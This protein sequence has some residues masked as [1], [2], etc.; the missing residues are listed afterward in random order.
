M[1]LSGGGWHALTL[2]EGRD[3]ASGVPATPWQGV[4]HSLQARSASARKS[5]EH[6]E[7]A[8]SSRR[9]DAARQRLFLAVTD[10]GAHAALFA[11]QLPPTFA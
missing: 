8:K 2:G 7:R 5:D 11:P 4:P 9:R 3:C 6:R 10:F 1:T